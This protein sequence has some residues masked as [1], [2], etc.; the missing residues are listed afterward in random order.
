MV[1]LFRIGGTMQVGDLVTTKSFG[2]MG[3]VL[4]IAPHPS[5]LIQIKWFDGYEDAYWYHPS[6]L[7][8]LVKP[9]NSET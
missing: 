8:T 6:N 5:N 2:G 4:Q 7:E 3:I 9:L 1:H